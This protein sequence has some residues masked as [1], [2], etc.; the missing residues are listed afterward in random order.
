[1]PS[2]GFM[3]SAASQKKKNESVHVIKKIHSMV[4]IDGNLLL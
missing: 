4:T 3:S 2:D 1:M